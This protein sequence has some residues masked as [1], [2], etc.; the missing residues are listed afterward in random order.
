MLTSYGIAATRTVTATEK[1][2]GVGGT[3]DAAR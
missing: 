2:N 1:K 3:L